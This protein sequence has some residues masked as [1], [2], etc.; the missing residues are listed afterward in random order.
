MIIVA[1]GKTLTATSTTIYVSPALPL[2]GG[3]VRTV[4][5]VDPLLVTQPV[6]VYIANDV[7]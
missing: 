1:T 5:V 7:D 3:E 2:V 4:L 6:Q